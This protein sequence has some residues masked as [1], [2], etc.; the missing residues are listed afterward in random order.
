MTRVLH[1]QLPTTETSR[2]A[3][4]ALADISVNVPL[5]F[6]AVDPVDLNDFDFM[7]PT[8]QEDPGNLLPEDGDMPAKL[9]ALAV[10][11]EDPGPPD[12]GDADIPA[13]YTYLAQ[14]IDHD[15]TFEV[16]PADLP[17]SESGAMPQ[18]LDPA[19]KPLALPVI[20]N[21]LRNFRTATLDLDHVY[22]LPA[23]RDATAPG[24]MRIGR[25]TALN[26]AAVPLLPVP[27]KGLDNDLPR[28]PRSADITHDRAALIGDPRNDE[29]TIISQLHVA[30]LKAHNALVD[31]GRS[32]E[33]ARRVLRQHYQH[34]V[35][36]DFLKRVADPAIVDEILQ[37]GNRW[38]NTLAEPFFM[39]LEFS[40]AAFRFGH[41]MVRPAY[42]FNTNFNFTA[43]GVPATLRLLF[44]F[45]SLSGQLG[46]GAGTET[47]PENWVIQWENFVDDGTG[48]FAKTRM[49]D[50]NLAGLAGAA[51]PNAAS[52]LFALQNLEGNKES[53]ADAA[54]LS[55]RNLLRGYR[56]RMPTGQAVANLLGVQVLSAAELEAAAISPAQKQALQDGGFTTA[57]P[58]WYYVLAEAKALGGGNRLGPV[59]STIVAEVLIGLVRR[60]DDSIL[61]T[62][63][64]APS[65][66]STPGTFDLP[67]LLRLA[68]VLDPV[69]DPPRTYIVQ[70]GDTLS[71][72]AQNELGDSSRWPEIFALNRATVRH[73]D[74]I[75]AGQVLILPGPDPIEPLPRFHIVQPG[76]TLS[77]IAAD[78]LG[79]ATR[80]PE[81][82][83]LNRDVISNPDI[84]VPGQ[85]LLLPS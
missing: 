46:N 34:V 52:G 36:H 80:W 78:E 13:G 45:S 27:G 3:R 21:A 17:P 82:F 49:L 84:I 71:S 38:F 44:T 22:G 72:I 8:L 70:S 69:A 2:M 18:L 64:W 33:E 57:T 42:K 54:R 76:D 53:P 10:T 15:I 41:T 6:A 32:F 77:A 28:E 7:F 24:K 60:S 30:F 12:P 58:L 31:Q 4:A 61:R 48:Q 11:M 37:N 75:F 39:P 29:N 73:P 5:A 85:V 68:G 40:V 83:A 65:L 67:D 66:G 74:R 62:P 55:V 19:M 63:G 59:G 43:P 16:Q 47:L 35:I 25:V 51:D 14:F 79:D 26:A 81:I 56:L 1:G 23:P 9:R 20:R 50:T